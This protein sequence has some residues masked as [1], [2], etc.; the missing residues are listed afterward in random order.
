[1]PILR[2]PTMNAHNSRVS[3]LTPDPPTFEAAEQK[4]SAF[5]RGQNFPA[6]ICWLIPGD[7]VVDN[8]RRYWVRDRRAK[9]AQYAARRYAEGIRRKLGILLQAICSNEVET[10]A[11][12]FVP[13][14]DLAAQYHLIG[15]GLKLSCPVER[16]ST[17]STTNPV[18]WLLLS[19][20]YGKQ[21]EMLEVNQRPF[22]P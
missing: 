5:L 18:R 17:T 6:R 12:V 14:D 16:C 22:Q 9:A 7:V 20:R 19:W 3:E 13:D 4:L 21:S 2:R 1:M 8:Q 11:S 10:F 15:R